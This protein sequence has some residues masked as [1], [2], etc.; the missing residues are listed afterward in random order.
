MIELDSDS[1][2]MDSYAS[3][4]DRLSEWFTDSVQFQK[5]NQLLKELELPSEGEILSANNG[6]VYE[7]S[8]HLTTDKNFFIW[9]Y[10]DQTEGQKAA[11]H[12][13][14]ENAS[15]T[16]VLEHF[17]G[18]DQA[19]VL[20][21]LN[22]KV[23]WNNPAF[24]RI[25]AGGNSLSAVGSELFER[26]SPKYITSKGL[27]NLK[28]QIANATIELDQYLDVQGI[29]GLKSLRIRSLRRAP[30]AQEYPYRLLYIESLSH[31]ST[32]EDPF[33]WIAKAIE[34]SSRPIF[35]LDP[36]GRIR[37]VNMGFNNFLGYSIETLQNH[38]FT[39]LLHDDDERLLFGRPLDEI[40]VSGEPAIPIRCL[41]QSGEI[42]SC[43]LTLER[44]FH[45]GKNWFIGFIDPAAAETHSNEKNVSVY[46]ALLDSLQIGVFETDMYGNIVYVNES[47]TA[48]LNIPSE[49]LMGKPIDSGV[50]GSISV[51]HDA[52]EQ[53]DIEKVSTGHNLV[54]GLKASWWQ[55]S[56]VLKK[57]PN[58]KIL[59]FVGGYRDI[60]EERVLRESLTSA[61][62]E[63]EETKRSRRT[64]ILKSSSELINPI[65]NLL[66]MV[67]QI[68]PLVE[69]IESAQEL[70]DNAMIQT[71]YLSNRI[72]NA[73]DHVKIESGEL[74]V[75]QDYFLLEDFT[76][77]TIEMWIGSS[78]QPNFPLEIERDPNLLDGYLGDSNRLTQIWVTILHEFSSRMKIQRVKLSIQ[79]NQAFK[80]AHELT[81]R[82]LIGWDTPASDSHNEHMLTDR[83]K[84]M[85]FDIRQTEEWIKLIKGK[86]VWFDQPNGFEIALTV[87][88]GL[89]ILD[90]NRTPEL[91]NMPNW[92]GKKILVAD[93]SE[94]IR[95]YIG[96]I[97]ESQGM[98]V[99]QAT[100]GIDA[101]RMAS[102]FQPDLILLDIQMPGLTGLEVTEKIRRELR[103]EV[104]IL[105]VTAS[106]Y[107]TEVQ[108]CLKAGMNDFILKP[109]DENQLLEKV[110]RL[111]LPEIQE[112][113]RL[114]SLQNL[115]QVS[116]GD[117]AFVKRM[118]SI[119]TDQI[120]K[121]IEELEAAME[122]KN[123]E[124]IKWTAHRI[125]PALANMQVNVVGPLIDLI[126]REEIESGN[127]IF[128][129]CDEFKAWLIELTEQLTEENLSLKES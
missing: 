107:Q 9:T 118:L 89:S 58:G 65:Q 74:V 24:N 101:L 55:S 95:L 122:Q 25:V 27:I 73:L 33:S 2:G 19:F 1:T 45:C 64:F 44:G 84:P 87:P 34:N 17:E 36:I 68:R 103:N 81:F 110:A 115:I 119:F 6:N 16:R 116:R 129:V 21:D 22:G 49:Q 7:R 15:L 50:L 121:A 18:M 48:M 78:A 43:L 76:K 92:S 117:A 86:L 37:W 127:R 85:P 80:N 31:D 94:W 28:L 8:F 77:K 11:L 46:Q 82:L 56:K 4:S 38:S 60:T 98:S 120:Q 30:W 125:K 88:L 105:A 79:F 5:N 109:F 42:M 52:S 47:L 97:L 112:G 10:R 61:R 23:I 123:K 91:G 67:S 124:R 12:L 41:H 59:G 90:Q 104:P 29:K 93:D 63:I 128:E 126:E 3:V 40:L 26:L 106:A 39:T 75:R 72:N 69:G 114:F 20:V 83:H 96:Q 32:Q 102:T 57:D 70:L 113:D 13:M 53:P 66:G 14:E 99:S 108:R 35:I 71:Q 111:L 51:I 54:D 100:D 62:W